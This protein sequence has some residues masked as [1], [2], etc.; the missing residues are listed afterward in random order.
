MHSYAQQ[1]LYT[2]EAA[3]GRVVF[4]KSLDIVGEVFLC[5]G[6]PVRLGLDEDRKMTDFSEKRRGCRI[7]CSVFAATYL[8]TPL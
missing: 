7:L 5:C 2:A 8:T 6:F 1:V 4:C 3:F